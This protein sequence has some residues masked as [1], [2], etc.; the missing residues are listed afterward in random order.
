MGV[1]SVNHDRYTEIYHAYVNDVDKTAL[2]Y[3]ENQHTA[4]EIVQEVFYKLYIHRENINLNAVR[5]WL[6]TTARRMALNY[7]R[8]HG[9]EIPVEE[10]YEDVSETLSGD[11]LEEEFMKALHDAQCREL[12]DKILD[13]MFC[14]N[15]RWYD[16]VTIT[17]GLEKPQKEVAEVMG[18]SLEGLHA[19]LYR[20]KKWI[21]KNYGKEYERLESM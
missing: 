13:E 19:M 14:K 2:H 15:E 16:A 4:E 9:R 3:S 5:G 11:D 17:Y 6:I 20:A 8:D 12:L 7:K 18:V 10:F 1:N 21:K